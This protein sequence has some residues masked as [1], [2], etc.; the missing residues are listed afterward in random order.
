M[1]GYHGNTAEAEK[2]AREEIILTFGKGFVKNFTGKDGTEWA[3][4]LIPNTDPQDRTPWAYF[5]VKAEQ[6]HPNKYGKSMWLKLSAEG[7][8]TVTG[9]VAEKGKMTES[10]KQAYTAQQ[11]KI[12]NKNLKLIVEAYKKEKPAE[13]AV[14]AE[15]SEKGLPWMGR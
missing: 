10:G 5:V 12:L 4:I 2:T 7:A 15:V 9:F 8:T 1:A 14:H 3:K 6:V 13:P 11:A